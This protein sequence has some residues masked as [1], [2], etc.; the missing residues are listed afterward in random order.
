MGS[1]KRQDGATISVS[2]VVCTGPRQCDEY[3][4]EL[5]AQVT[6]EQA[7]ANA[8]RRGALVAD[9]HDVVDVGVWGRKVL[10]SQVLRDGDR[11]EIYRALRVDP[12]VARRERFQTQGAR[13]T[14]LFARRRPNAKPGY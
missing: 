6:V 9:P 2:L 8:R 1:E 10:F 13:R 12:K 14:G 7:L 4:L 5:S 11:L 3:A